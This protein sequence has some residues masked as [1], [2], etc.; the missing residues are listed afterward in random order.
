MSTGHMKPSDTKDQGPS[1][2]FNC[3]HRVDKSAVK[4]AGVMA[5]I[6]ED[7]VQIVVLAGMAWVAFSGDIWVKR[8]R[9]HV[10]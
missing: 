4:K 7:V 10:S 9:T 3:S 1:S 2:V 6:L 5:D 8:E